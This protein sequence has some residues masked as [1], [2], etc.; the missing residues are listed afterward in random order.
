VGSVWCGGATGKWQCVG[1][2]CGK[3][4]VQCV[5]GMCVC[6]WVGSVHGR[7]VA[8]NPVNGVGVGASRQCGERGTVVNSE[9][10]GAWCGKCCKPVQRVVVVWERGCVAMHCRGVCSVC[11]A[12]GA[13]S[14]GKA[15]SVGGGGVGC[16][17]GRQA[18]VCES[19]CGTNCVCM[20]KAWHCRKCHK[21]WHVNRP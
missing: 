11:V 12:G 3:G 6:V 15:G 16:V 14:V 4:Q 5:A 18:G 19:A 10:K 1:C 13:G 8:G 2:V 21:A 17:A 20:C 7:C 9:P